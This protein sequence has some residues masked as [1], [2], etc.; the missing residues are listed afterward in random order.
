MRQLLPFSLA[1]ESYALALEDIQEVVENQTIYP[2]PAAPE[3]VVGAIGFH[4][5]IVPVVDLAALLGFVSGP[6]GARLIVLVNDYGPLA[7]GVH[8]VHPIITFE[9]ET[10][11]F[12]HNPPERS[13][14]TG[15]LNRAGEMLSLL[16]L[17]AVIAELNEL[18]IATG[19]TRAQARADR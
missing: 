12:L 16:D 14:I 10:D 9:T 8:H 7:L 2:F 19:G 6:L 18:C 5:R 17:N 4:G 3:A 11:E 15:V 13:F 1:Y